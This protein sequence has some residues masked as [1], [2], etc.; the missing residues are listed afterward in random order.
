MHYKNI[1]VE[2]EFMVRGMF[3]AKNEIIEKNDSC[4]I[5][6]SSKKRRWYMRAKYK[7]INQ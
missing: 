3:T 6:N 7:A 4:I 1:R 5:I 2:A